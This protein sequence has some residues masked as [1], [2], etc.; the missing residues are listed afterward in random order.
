MSIAQNLN[1]IKESLAKQVTLVAVSKTKPLSD[2]MQAYH[3]GQRVFGENKIQDMAEKYEAMPKD[4]QWHMIGHV[5]RNKVKYMA[6][7]VSLIH[8]VDSLKLLEEIDEF[9]DWLEDEE[10]KL[11]KAQ[12]FLE[13]MQGIPIE[14][15]NLAASSIQPNFNESPDDFYNRCVHT[16]NPGVISLNGPSMFVD[17]ALELPEPQIKTS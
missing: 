2:I 4:I 6:G 12:D 17:L 9:N 8:G 15:Y 13:D 10:E 7:F 16:G 1:K 3:A 5:Q 11:Q 14:L